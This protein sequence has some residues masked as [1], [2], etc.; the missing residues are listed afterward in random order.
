MKKVLALSGSIRKDSANWKILE[1]IAAMYQGRFEVE[2]YDGL[3]DLPHF[4]PDLKGDNVPDAVKSFY[5]KINN[6]DAILV[7]TPEYVFSPPAILKNA[8]E[9]TVA[10]TILSY[11]PTAMIV[12]SSA[13]DSTYASLALILKTLIQEELPEEQMLLIKGVRGKVN[14]EGNINDENTLTDIRNVMD[15]LSRH[16]ARKQEL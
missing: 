10:Q 4:D 5:K 15:A 1:H 12:A 16:I 8:L 14:G 6:A 3:S 9:W 7:C 2:L 11:K 13:G